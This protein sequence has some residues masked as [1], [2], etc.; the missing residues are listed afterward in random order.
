MRVG[1]G[2]A[3]SAWPATQGCRSGAI[4][5]A[6]QGEWGGSQHALLLALFHVA[7]RCSPCPPVDLDEIRRCNPAL[8][9][10]LLFAEPIDRLSCDPKEPPLKVYSVPCAGIGVVNP[11]EEHF[12]YDDKCC[13]E[14]VGKAVK[15][16]KRHFGKDLAGIQIHVVFVGLCAGWLRRRRGHHVEQD[17]FWLGAICWVGKQLLGL[18]EAVT[19]GT[20]VRAGSIAFAIVAVAVAAM[21]VI[22]ATV[23]ETHGLYPWFGCACL[24]DEYNTAQQS[25]SRKSRKG[26]HDDRMI[27]PAEQSRQACPIRGE[28]GALGACRR[29]IA[30]FKHKWV[31][32]EKDGSEKGSL[33]GRKVSQ[34][35]KPETGV[36]TPEYVRS[37]SCSCSCSCSIGGQAPRHGDI[38]LGMMMIVS[39]SENTNGNTNENESKGKNIV[40]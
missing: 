16:A 38:G 15:G 8:A 9:M 12:P 1:Q 31:F 29:H 22:V 32:M 5:R 35:F 26:F 14:I 6:D 27:F 25:Q 19:A 4:A 13:S 2:L 7:I 30:S 18:V 34:D 33:I 21:L 39:K 10:A 11:V 28:T 40:I 37:D 36:R 24:A 20:M 23:A 3:A 17:C